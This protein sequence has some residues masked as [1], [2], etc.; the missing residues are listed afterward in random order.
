MKTLRS[1]GH[2][3]KLIS[4]F[5]KEQSRDETPPPQNWSKYFSNWKRKNVCKG[6]AVLRYIKG[7]CLWHDKKTRH[8]GDQ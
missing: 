2:T 3:Q 8:H 6:N 7:L 4:N 1:N 5:F